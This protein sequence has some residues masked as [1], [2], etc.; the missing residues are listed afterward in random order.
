MIR[1]EA[2]ILRILI[3]ITDSYKGNS[4]YEQIVLKAGEF[5]IA[6]VTVLRGLSGFGTAGRLHAAKFLRLPDDL[7]I[8]I[9]MV[10]TEENLNKLK[11]FLHEEVGKGLIMQEKV[12]AMKYEVTVK[13][14]ESK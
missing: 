5:H 14:K 3:G 10:D 6:N 1:Q 9:E 2:I 11:M 13:N 12:C 8:V 7:P 4:L